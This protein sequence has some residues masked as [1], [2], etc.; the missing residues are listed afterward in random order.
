MHYLCESSGM[1]VVGLL[2]AKMLKIKKQENNQNAI[3]F[4][5][6]FLIFSDGLF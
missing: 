3:R 1:D 6:I 4:V 5:F 2:F